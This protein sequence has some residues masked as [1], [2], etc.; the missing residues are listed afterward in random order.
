MAKPKS[1][2]TKKIQSELE[3][4]VLTPEEEKHI[5][6]QLLKPERVRK[7]FDMFANSRHVKYGVASD[8][9]I[10]SKYFRPDIF[11]QSIETFTREGV[12][13]ILIPGDVIEGMS[14]REGHIYELE[15]IGTSAQVQKA[16]ELLK[17]F[18]QP[19]LFTTGNHDEWAK[20]KSNQGVLVGPT[21]EAGVKGSK[22]LGE[23]TADLRLSPQT[24][25]RL[26]H[27]GAASYALSYSGQKRVAALSHDEKPAVILNGHIHKSLYMNIRNLHY[28][29]CGTFQDQTPFMR[30]KGSPAMVGYWV[31][32]IGHNRKGV[33]RVDQTWFPGY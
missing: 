33:N 10:G 8:L 5:L 15:T 24:F 2:T 28:F 7:S 12:D 22:W 31:I 11:E 14:N 9:H 17:G 23:Y 20:N 4:L 16:I 21:I 6:Q 27:E 30:M 13:A 29:E 26:T 18:K 1:S 32:G 19:I 25:I 3:R